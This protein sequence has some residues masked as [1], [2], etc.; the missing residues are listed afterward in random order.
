M[1]GAV[2]LGQAGPNMESLSTAAG[3]AVNIYA[4]IDRVSECFIS[5]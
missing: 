5:H 2:S 4:T 1:V 3:A